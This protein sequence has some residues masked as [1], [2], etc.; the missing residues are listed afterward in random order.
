MKAILVQL[1]N[2][3]LRL[4]QIAIGIVFLWSSYEHLKN[5]H[6]FLISIERYH[7]FPNAVS[8]LIAFLIPNVELVL[9]I[10]LLVNFSPSF[11]K[12][13]AGTM[14]FLFG[15]LQAT[16]LF[17]GLEID[18]GCFGGAIDKP[19]TLVSCISSFLISA[20]LILSWKFQNSI[21]QSVGFKNRILTTHEST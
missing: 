6:Y 3:T 16:A 18:C 7:L 19:I 10:F 12:F 20:V 1:I 9:G 14:F 4:A 2:L 8:R 15:V 13:A 17:R 11:S 21:S 5:S